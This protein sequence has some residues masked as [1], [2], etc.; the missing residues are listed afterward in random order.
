MKTQTHKTY[1]VA[2]RR[3]RQ[4]KTDYHKR[5]RLLMASK[6]RLVIR[7]SLKS[8]NAQIVD[9][10][11]KGDK[12]IA[13]A[14]STEL[15]KMGWNY[16]CRNVP[17]AYLLGLLIA[18]KAKEKGVNDSILDIGMQK[19]VP[20]ARIYAVLKG[21]TD[22][23]LVIPHSKEVLPEEKRIMGKHIEEY[24]SKL[25]ED[26]SKKKFG[27]YNKNGADPKRISGL[28]NDIKNKIIGA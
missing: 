20:G 14:N 22:N 12:V 23:G 27:G 7:K 4:G 28:F 21:A 26:E 17:S 19:S 13:S 18:K 8:I 10:S 15:K 1:T 3:K 5:L 2:Y 6:P 11:D 9:F 24:A 16:N 25:G